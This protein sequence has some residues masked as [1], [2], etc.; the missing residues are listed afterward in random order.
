MTRDVYTFAI[1][2][3][4]VFVAVFGMP[5]VLSTP[6]H[7]EVCPFMSMSDQPVICSAETLLHMK[8]WQSALAT[9]LAEI[10]VLV[11][12]ALAFFRK[13]FSAFTDT[14]QVRYRARKRVPERVTLFQEL[15]SRGI[16][17]R[18]EPHLFFAT[19]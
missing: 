19:S 13:P 12:L 14:G 7:H 2:T 17:N 4:F 16:L 15:F 1:L 10:L 18:K 11:A 6:M 5:L 3:V 8:H 9:I